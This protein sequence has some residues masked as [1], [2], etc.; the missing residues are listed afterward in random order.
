MPKPIPFPVAGK[1]L[2][3]APPGVP[4]TPVEAEIKK[5]KIKEDPLIETKPKQVLFTEETPATVPVKE[6]IPELSPQKDETPDVTPQKEE[7]PEVVPQKEELPSTLNPENTVV[8][9]GKPIEIKPTK[10]KYFRNK[11]TSSYGYIKAIPL[12]ELLTFEKGVLDKT[13]DAD[14]IL[15]NFLVAVFDDPQFVEENY[16]EMTADE[17]DQIVKIF[18]RI[19]HIDEKEEVAR[20]NKEAQAKH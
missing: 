12:T 19:N 18:G 8:V 16:D 17:I 14:Q 13:K 15:Y 1:E 10:L 11:T 5:A 3:S 20:K 2:P 4:P 7:I 6:D 9:C